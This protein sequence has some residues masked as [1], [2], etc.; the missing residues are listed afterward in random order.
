MISLLLVKTNY[1]RLAR[2]YHPDRAPDA[3]KSIANE[4]FNILHQAYSILS[5]PETKKLYD[6]GN[7]NILFS[8]PTNVGKWEH[9]IAPLTSLAIE[10]ARRK[11]QGSDAEK[12]DILRETLI[13]KGSM[14]HL[15][16]TIP[17][18]RIE[19]EPRIIHFIKES[20][21]WGKIPKVPIRKMRK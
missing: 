18:I 20:M 7:T 21:E 10:N 16:N 11:Y 5:N 2:I 1:Y 19:D 15:L 14:T 4:K 17:F 3:E 12:T 9:H 6:T 13:G 8:K